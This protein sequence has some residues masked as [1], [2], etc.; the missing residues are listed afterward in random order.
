MVDVNLLKDLGTRTGGIKA[1]EYH[2]RKAIDWIDVVKKI[3]L[4]ALPIV[5]CIV[6]GRF[7][8]YYRSLEVSQ[9]RSVIEQKKAEIVQLDEKLKVSGSLNN[10]N[11]DI[12]NKID[13]LKRIF[14]LRHL[15]VKILDSVRASIPDNIHLKKLDFQNNNQTVYLSGIS[16]DRNGINTFRTN[17]NRYPV[18]DYQ[19]INVTSEKLVNDGEAEVVDFDITARLADGQN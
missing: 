18:F 11:N 15:V 3:L 1:K 19:Q 13:E 6:G 4:C 8:F 5:L 12:K 17:L 9:L 16:S 2:L 14:F 10:E 7:Y